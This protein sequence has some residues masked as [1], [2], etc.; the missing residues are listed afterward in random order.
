MSLRAS[1]WHGEDNAPDFEKERRAGDE[2]RA[3]RQ[4]KINAD[5]EKFLD[6]YAALEAAANKKGLI[7]RFGFPATIA[8]LALVATLITIVSD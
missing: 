5:A 6:R 8:A 2:A 7:E 1:T 4:A 3:D